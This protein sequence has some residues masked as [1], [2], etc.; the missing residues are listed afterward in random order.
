MNVEP[1]LAFVIV[2]VLIFY[3]R[4]IIIQRQRAKRV[5][6]APALVSK[7]KKKAQPVQQPAGP[8]FSILSRKKVDLAI[9][10]AGILGILVGVALNAGW[11]IFPAL[12]PYWWL[13]TGLG[14]IGFSWAFKL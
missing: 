5:L 14:I 11:V 10:G 3:L 13:P 8:G 4:L 2:A 9:A 7:N 1:G 6:R 12:Q